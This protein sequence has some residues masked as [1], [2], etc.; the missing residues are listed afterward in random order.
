MALTVGNGPFGATPSGS[1]NFTYDAP[2]RVLYLEHNP[3]RIR[4]VIDGQT[5]V[6][7]RRARLLH[8]TELM[9]VHYFPAEDV[10][11]D[12]LEPTDHTT[13][14][15][16]KGDAS[17]WTVT[18]GDRHRQ[19]ALWS[20]REPLAGAR[21]LAG[22]MALYWDAVDEW[23]EEAERAEVHPRDPYHRCDVVRSD[24]HVIVRLG[25]HVLA[26][27]R[28]PTMLFETGLPPRF[29]LPLQDVSLAFLETSDRQTQCPYKGHTNRYYTA[30]VGGVRSEDVAWV[31]KEPYAE[32]RGI[33]GLVAF[34]NE[35]VDLEVDGEVWERPTTRLV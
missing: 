23:W 16:Y 22:L 26:D 24:R 9:P 31:Y 27:S 12:L 32:V 34:Y 33:E 21:G 30:S 35:K 5:V 8:E 4:A 13:H 15:P 18:A 10:R 11:L 14:C 17:Y 3:R 19:N 25:D 20:Y 2:A 1:F 28:Q 29:Y 6:D 7:S